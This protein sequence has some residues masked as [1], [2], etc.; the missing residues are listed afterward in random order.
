MNEEFDQIENE[1]TL[2]ERGRIL[3][4]VSPDAWEIIFDTIRQYA[5]AATL[6]LRRL[7]PGDPSVPT[8]HAAWYALNSFAEKFPQDIQNSLDF[9]AKP[10]DSLKKYIN[11]VRE[12]SDV[13]VMQ[14]QE[15]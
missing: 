10:S 8:A 2:F 14:G 5:E 7:T 1:L 9:A 6:D 15:R 13:I 12:A 4:A 3:R 11:G